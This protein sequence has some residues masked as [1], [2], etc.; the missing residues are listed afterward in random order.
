MREM[1]SGR[2]GAGDAGREMRGGSRGP[3]CGSR[4]VLRSQ[5]DGWGGGRK[6]ILT[7]RS[8]LKLN[9]LSIFSKF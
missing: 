5:V 2:C 6:S 7:T 4:G 1:R 8:G 3:R 9:S